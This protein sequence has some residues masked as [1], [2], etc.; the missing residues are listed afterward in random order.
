[1]K[2]STTMTIPRRHFLGSSLVVL[3]ST[4]LDALTTPLWKW[5]KSG[6]AAGRLRNASYI[7][8]AVRRRRAEKPA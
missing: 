6:C 3:G 8:R 2:K 4:L 1:M 7:S 5:S